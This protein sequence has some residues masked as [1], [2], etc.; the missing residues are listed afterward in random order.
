[1]VAPARAGRDYSFSILQFLGN[2]CHGRWALPPSP[3]GTRRVA[4]DLTSRRQPNGRGDRACT[5]EDA[6]GFFRKKAS[7]D[8]VPIHPDN[9][10]NKDWMILLEAGTI[11]GPSPQRIRVARW[12]QEKKIVK[13]YDMFLRMKYFVVVEAT[14]RAFMR[15]ISVPSSSATTPASSCR[16]RVKRLAS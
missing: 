13:K 15:F 16:W 5:T 3:D 7:N 12:M 14:I 10:G 8:M 1:M 2:L 9:I 11:I 6:V 4:G